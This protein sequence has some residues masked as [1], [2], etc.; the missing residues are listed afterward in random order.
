MV[1]TNLAS[2]KA[3]AQRDRFEGLTALATSDDVRNFSSFDL[4]D[5]IDA[6]LSNNIKPCD[7]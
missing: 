7:C 5:F 4:T 1:V 2:S 3:D 6:N